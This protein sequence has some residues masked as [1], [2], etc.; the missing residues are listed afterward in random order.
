MS[1]KL[2]SSSINNSC[3]TPGVYMKYS[4]P[5]ES[6][7]S[8]ATASSPT[9]VPPPS[10]GGW[11]MN[12]AGTASRP[13]LLRNSCC[14]RLSCARCS[15]RHSRANS[16]HPVARPH[17]TQH[18]RKQSAGP[19]LRPKQGARRS[20]PAV[21]AGAASQGND[22]SAGWCQARTTEVTRHPLPQLAPGTRHPRRHQVRPHAW[23][24]QHHTQ[25]QPNTS[26]ELAG[27]RLH[28]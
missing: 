1:V 27:E 8:L 6:S 3:T 23:T 24:H 21:S 18:V 12:V 9:N 2:C 19:T 22:S 7:A 11:S 10:P 20:S 25:P 13:M 14:W 15:H 26:T 28:N 4:L 16:N 5:S 17:P